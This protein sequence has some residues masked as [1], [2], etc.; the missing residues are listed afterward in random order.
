MLKLPVTSEESQSMIEGRRLKRFPV[1]QE[2]LVSFF[3]QGFRLINVES[4]IPSTAKF[5]N[6]YFDHDRRHFVVIFEDESFPLYSFGS[7]IPL[8]PPPTVEILY[9]GTGML[10]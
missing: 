3:T 1:S 6:A 7:E 5:F 4:C 8:S 9:Q 10:V 2:A